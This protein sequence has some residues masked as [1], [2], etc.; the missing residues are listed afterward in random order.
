MG[1]GGTTLH[2]P[3][4]GH[5]SSQGQCVKVEGRGEPCASS[6]GSPPWSRTW[7]VGHYLPSVSIQLLRYT[8]CVLD[9]WDISQAD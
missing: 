6:R 7:G 4:N 3:I 9:M 8:K 1:G 2:A 5:S